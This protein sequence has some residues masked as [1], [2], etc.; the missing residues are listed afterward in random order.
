M[1]IGKFWQV[2]SPAWG[3]L[4]GAEFWAAAHV[5]TIGKRWSMVLLV[6]A[7]EGWAASAARRLRKLSGRG[8][9]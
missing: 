3:R 9:A 6:R 7:G 1:I 5:A 4:Y 8:A 2:T